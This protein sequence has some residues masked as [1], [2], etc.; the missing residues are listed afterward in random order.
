[1]N[2]RYQVG[3]S[4]GWDAPS[5]VVRQAD[6][7][8][9]Q[10]L[11]DGELCYVFNA[12]QMGKSSLRV[13]TMRELQL[14]GVRCGV[15]DA[16]LL[17]SQLTTPEQWYASFA[18]SVA[19]SFELDIHVP[20][21]WRDHDALSVIAR[22]TAFFE[23][24]LEQVS[25]PVVIFLDEIDHTLGLPFAL[26][27]FFVFLRAIYDRRSSDP[28]FQR[29]TWALLGVTTPY[30]LMND[31]QASGF[32]LGRAIG[33]TGFKEHEVF[34]LAQGL[35]DYVPQPMTVL[36]EILRWTNGQPF[37]TQKLCTL[38]SKASESSIQ[39]KLQLPP[40][41]EGYWID[42]LVH[43]HLLKDWEVKDNPE[44]LRTIR[45]RLVQSAR[46][47]SLLKLYAA[48]LDSQKPFGM[49]EM[50]DEPNSEN[51]ALSDLNS[52]TLELVLTGLVER[53]NQGLVVK[54]QL[55]QEIFSAEWLQQQQALIQV[56]MA[57]RS[58]RDNLRSAEGNRRKLSD[59][60]QSEPL[61]DLEPTE[62]T[63]LNPIKPSKNAMEGFHK[64]SVRILIL[65]LTIGFAIGL[66]LGWWLS[67]QSHNDLRR[68]FPINSPQRTTRFLTHQSVSAF[69][70]GNQIRNSI[71]CT[72]ADRT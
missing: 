33:L 47:P 32:N 12:R 38:V 52:L 49:R 71:L 68:F 30:D 35:V 26:D 60:R 21:W 53:T 63:P 43:N 67:A 41:T 5:Y 20:K 69:A 45:D 64:R 61:I 65:G 50:L 15:I 17:G 62:D 48:M 1:M 2:Y 51:L 16:T 72:N 42:Q 18:C 36:R 23:F 57:R 44:H 19:Q 37:L 6:L 10:A 28:R 3:G 13:R 14:Q 8:F 9:L 22:L 40:G 7:D 29:L 34:P 66:G 24:F 54:N 56:I 25:D 58:Y 4:L 59:R 11:R 55:Y 39:G 27:D 31:P 70:N 46:S